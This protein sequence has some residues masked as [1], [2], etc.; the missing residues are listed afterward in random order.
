MK[1]HS[2][3]ARSGEKASGSKIEKIEKELK[4]MTPYTEK[5]REKLDILFAHE[6][7]HRE[8]KEELKEVDK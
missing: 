2:G 3:F 6:H 8:L 4:D 7:K 5:W 1:Y